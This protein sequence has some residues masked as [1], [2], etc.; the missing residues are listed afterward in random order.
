MVCLLGEI[1]RDEA[2]YSRIFFTVEYS[3]FPGVT[4]E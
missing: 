1:T 2:E 4:L 3:Q